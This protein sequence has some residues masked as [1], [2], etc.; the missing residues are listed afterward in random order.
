M[1]ILVSR[2]A[3]DECQVHPAGSLYGTGGGAE[4]PAAVYPGIAER[5][6][7]YVV[8][9][10]HVGP[11]GEWTG[12]GRSALWAPGGALL[13][14]AQADARMSMVVTAEVG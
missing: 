1:S 13:A 12:C 6:G 10:N 7:L 8:V 2:G 14:L 11:A 3:T 4:E 9:A 5:F